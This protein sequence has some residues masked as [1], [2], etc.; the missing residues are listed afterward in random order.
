MVSGTLP[1]FAEVLREGRAHIWAEQRT[2]LSAS[3]SAAYNCPGSMNWVRLK[4]KNPGPR[5]WCDAMLSLT[6]IAGGTRKKRGRAPEI[7]GGVLGLFD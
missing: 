3:W 5:R 6:E 4:K 1:D 2:V 7:A